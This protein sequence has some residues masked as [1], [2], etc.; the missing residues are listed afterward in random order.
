MAKRLNHVIQQIAQ[1]D[2]LELHRHPPRF[3]PGQIQDVVDQR[4]QVGSRGIN[5][6]RK[7]HLLGRQVVIGIF[8]QYFGQ[9]QQVVQRRPKLVRHI[10]QKLGLVLRSQCQLFRLLFQLL[11]G[12]FHFKILLFDLLVLFGQ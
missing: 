2:L 4:E 11:L 6:L 7:F 5:R 1:P 12:L 10:G 3:D 8:R 9:E